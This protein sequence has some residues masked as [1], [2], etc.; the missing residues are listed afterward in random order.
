MVN[1]RLRGLRGPRVPSGT[2][3]G[4]SPGTAGPGEPH[5]IGLQQLRAMGVATQQD[6]TQK[7]Q[8]AASG[9]AT[10]I[11]A[12]YSEFGDGDLSLTPTSKT[13]TTARNTVAATAARTITIQPGLQSGAICL[14]SLLMTTFAWT[15]KDSGGATL[16]TVTPAA[17]TTIILAWTG[18]AWAYLSKAT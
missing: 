4:R 16:V 6:V 17:E 1:S 5:P 14:V 9:A 2:I 15:L 18:A 12:A 13:V 10:G 7:S 8:A 11:A 3:L